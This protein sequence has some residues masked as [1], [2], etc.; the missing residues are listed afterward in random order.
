MSKVIRGGEDVCLIV[1]ID[2][3]EQGDIDI[4]V[5]GAA[6]SPAGR[7]CSPLRAMAL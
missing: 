4:G 3:G 6:R 7:C 5:I 2:V 1:E